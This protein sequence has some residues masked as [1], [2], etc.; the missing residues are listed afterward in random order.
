MGA[1]C[2]EEPR[3]LGHVRNDM[4]DPEGLSI[5]GS[6]SAAWLRTGENLYSHPPDPSCP[7]SAL[8]ALLAHLPAPFRAF[9]SSSDSCPRCSCSSSIE[10][11]LFCIHHL[12]TLLSANAETDDEWVLAD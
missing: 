9:R 4:G 5:P 1:W 3:D 10:I 12:I 7:T 6:D 11:H 8:A 2:W